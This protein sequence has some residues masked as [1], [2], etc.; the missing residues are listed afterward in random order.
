MAPLFHMRPLMPCVGLVVLAGTFTFVV[1]P[2]SDFAAPRM[3]EQVDFNSLPT[4]VIDPGHGG[5]DN[6]SSN[7]SGMR[8]KDLTLDIAQRVEQNLKSANFPTV[9]TRTDDR[10]VALSERVEVANKLKNSIFVSIHLN[11]DSAEWV[12]GME[13]FYADQKSTPGYAWSWIGLF[14]KPEG[15]ELDTG[16]TLAGFVQASLVTKLSSANRGIKADNLYVVRNVRHAAVLVEAGFLSN[17][18]EAQLLSNPDYRDRLAGAIA[19]GVVSY[20]RTR[21]RRT[22]PTELADARR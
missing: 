21:P 5:K 3:A 11:A 16:E 2:D 12:T 18:F 13:T 4:V 7:K 1:V 9:L 8:E 20:Q 15:P 14:S 17:T 10:Y 22:V 19:E 6:G